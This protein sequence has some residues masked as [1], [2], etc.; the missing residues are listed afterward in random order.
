MVKTQEFAQKSNALH[1]N[2]YNYNKTD[3]KNSYTKVEIVC[4]DHG[5]FTQRPK[6]HLRSG[7][8]HTGCPKCGDHKAARSRTK[9]TDYFLEKARSIHGDK[10]DYSRVNYKH[11]HKN[12]KII[13]KKH[14]LEFEVTPSNFFGNIHNCPECF[15]EINQN[16][17]LSLEEFVKECREIH[18]DLYD[19]SIAE[20]SGI[21]NKVDN[22]I[23]KKH[24]PFS[25]VGY[26]HKRGQGCP[27]CSTS[28][29]ELSVKSYL[30][31][32]SIKFEQQKTFD[33]C[34]YKGLLKF[35]FYLPDSNTCIEFQGRQHF[36]CVDYFGGED[37]FT[38]IQIRDKIKQDFCRSNQINLICV[39]EG[40]IL[41]VALRKIK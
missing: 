20:Y 24:G 25:Q 29:G 8:L 27:N 6:D 39:T 10:F 26:A 3:Y 12:V 16:I 13:C 2:K 23:C 35:D 32:N 36:E 5:V 28:K 38:E 21:T 4:K 40:D 14:S 17:R 34:V 11:T 15:K 31:E 9:S 41:D 33:G 7:G 37:G 19:Y 1:N 22:I 18:K 30:E